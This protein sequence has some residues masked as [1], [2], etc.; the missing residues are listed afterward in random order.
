MAAFLEG[1]LA[2]S[3]QS[4]LM[5]AEGEENRRRGR[6]GHQ[7]RTT[8]NQ[9]GGTSEMFAAVVALEAEIFS[10]SL[11]WSKDRDYPSRGLSEYR[12]RP[13]R[14]IGVAQCVRAR[15]HQDQGKR[16]D[17]SAVEAS[18]PPWGTKK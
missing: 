15:V 11:R 4:D 9:K 18:D 1:I 16:G 7:W 14:R 10:R 6:G 8:K 17:D 2:S 3:V 12:H 5:T 13:G